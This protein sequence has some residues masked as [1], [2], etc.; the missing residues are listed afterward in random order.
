MIEKQIA[1]KIKLIRKS[2]GMTL[3]Q[4]GDVTNLSKGLLSRVENNLVSPP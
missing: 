4:L 2:K 3:A 1:D